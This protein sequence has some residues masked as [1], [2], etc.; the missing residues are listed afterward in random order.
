MKTI[1]QGKTQSLL[2]KYV[3]ANPMSHFKGSGRGADYREFDL[4]GDPVGA[5]NANLS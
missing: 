5:P 2:I 4:E 1:P 3:I